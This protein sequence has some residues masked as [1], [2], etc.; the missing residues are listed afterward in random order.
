MY[1]ISKIRFLKASDAEKRIVS[2]SNIMVVSH[3]SQFGQRGLKAK[4]TAVAPARE[5]IP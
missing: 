2:S 4:F 3:F 5:L 1:H